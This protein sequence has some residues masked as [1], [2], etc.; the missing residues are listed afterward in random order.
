M[1]ISTSYKEGFDLHTLVSTHVALNGTLDLYR[2][3]MPKYS[4]R[5]RKITSVDPFTLNANPKKHMQIK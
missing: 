5:S 2:S 3:S 4:Q 1:E